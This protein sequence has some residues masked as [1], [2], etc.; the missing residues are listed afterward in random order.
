VHKRFRVTNF[1]CVLAL[2]LLASGC[3]L[4]VPEREPEVTPPEALEPED[5]P[6]SLSEVVEKWLDEADR[7]LSQ[8]RLLEPPGDNAHDRY[9][10]V[11]YL[12]PGNTRAQS[13]LHAIVLRYL[14]MARSAAR[15][16][17]YAQSR[18]L[19][20]RANTVDPGNPLVQELIAGVQEE[21]E[22]QRQR[23]EQLAGED[24]YPLDPALLSQRDKHLA[25]QLGELGRRVRDT[26]EFV[27]IV[28][29]TDDEGRW[30][31]QQMQEAVPDH[32]VRG[33]IQLGAPPRVTFQP[34]L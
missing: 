12:D 10:A 22:R 21:Q 24:S 11:L 23:D 7:A 20:K 26:G 19:L 15:R 30:I 32:L 17:A 34:P 33:D 28:S 14:D 31:Y 8:D 25:E 29:R 18:E 6:Y 16:G 9:R 27:L 13:G 1:G 2:A 4:F 5:P 3:Q